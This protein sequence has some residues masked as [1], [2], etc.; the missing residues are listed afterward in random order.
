[1]PRLTRKLI[2]P[3]IKTFQL[4]RVVAEIDTD[5]Y[6][7]NAQLIP[8][9]MWIGNDAIRLSINFEGRVSLYVLI[10]NRLVRIIPIVVRYF[11]FK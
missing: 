3:V 10:N 6:V 1:M 11:L 2:W 8:I 9:F 5:N 7:L 4:K